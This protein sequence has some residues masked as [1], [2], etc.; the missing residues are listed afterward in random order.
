[1]RRIPPRPPLGAGDSPLAHV[2]GEPGLKGA[3]A[4]G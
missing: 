1:V 2:L 3:H 4:S